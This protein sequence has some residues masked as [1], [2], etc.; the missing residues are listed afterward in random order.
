MGGHLAGVDEVVAE[1][2][3]VLGGVI[4]HLEVIV[5][6]GLAVEGSGAEITTPASFPPVS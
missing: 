2:A 1:R 3:V 4:V 6:A 5:Q